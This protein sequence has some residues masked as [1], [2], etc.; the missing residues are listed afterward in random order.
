[1]RVYLSVPI[2]ANNSLDTAKV[3]AKAIAASGHELAS[4]WV[5][6]DG[7]A[8]P[9]PTVNIFERDTSAVEKCDA[10]VADVSRPSTGVGMEVMAAHLAGKRIILVAAEGATVS[11]MLT[12]MRSAEWVWFSDE[13]SLV[14][15]LREKLAHQRGASPS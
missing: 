6:T 15:G 12:D 7:E 3:I 14:R 11:R 13:G 9:S 10:V 1:M 5:L 8:R 4:P 2:I